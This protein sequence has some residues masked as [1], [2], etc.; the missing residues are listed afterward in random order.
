M[1]SA[2]ASL[3]SVLCLAAGELLCC[4]SAAVMACA[5]LHDLTSQVMQPLLQ[6]GNGYAA[7]MSWDLSELLL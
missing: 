3:Q 6:P 5:G 2:V 4:C 1:V 7:C